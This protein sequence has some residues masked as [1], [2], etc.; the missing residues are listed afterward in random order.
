MAVN[1][2]TDRFAL[3]VVRG[4]R[5][6]FTYRYETWVQYRSRRPKARVDL[7]PLAEELTAAEPGAAQWFAEPPGALAPVLGLVDGDESGLEP[8]DV[9]ARV[10]RHL[11]PPRRHGTPTP[12][13]ERP[14]PRQRWG[15]PFDLASIAPRT[16]GAIDASPCE[17]PAAGVSRRR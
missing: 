14:T 5:Y 15:R 4:R 9:V 1:N 10:A 6:R 8:D 2:A 16:R 12:W 11:E 13:A 3:L 7:A 17:C